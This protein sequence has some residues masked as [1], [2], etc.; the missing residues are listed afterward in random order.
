[1]EHSSAPFVASRPCTVEDLDV[2]QWQ[3]LTSD[4]ILSRSQ[5]VHLWPPAV[6]QI[7]TPAAE[8]LH[9]GLLR[10]NSARSVVPLQ[11]N[12]DGTA[13]VISL[14]HGA[15]EFVLT[16]RP[17]T[18]VSDMHRWRKIYAT[19]DNVV[20]AGNWTDLDRL[21]WSARVRPLYPGETM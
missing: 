12:M 3:R 17:S 19:L 1:M 2:P 14:G 5:I 21:S 13:T 9:E 16:L 10:Y 20:A 18:Q 8:L 6:I 7:L 11:V 4:L 15:C